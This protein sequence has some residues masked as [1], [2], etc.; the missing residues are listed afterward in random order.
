MATW[1]YET[2]NGRMPTTIDELWPYLKGPVS[3]GTLKEMFRTP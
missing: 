3:E 1:A 2:N